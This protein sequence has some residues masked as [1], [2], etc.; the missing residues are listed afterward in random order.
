MVSVIVFF[1]ERRKKGILCHFDE[2]RLISQVCLA[3][4]LVTSKMVKA[5]ENIHGLE[6]KVLL[7]TLKGQPIPLTFFFKLAK[8]NNK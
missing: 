1:E 6:T 3:W 5:G 2:Y 8:Q 7:K 4:L